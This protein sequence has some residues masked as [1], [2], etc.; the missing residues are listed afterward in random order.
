MPL[1][2]IIRKVGGIELGYVAV[3]PRNEAIYGL[4]KENESLCYMIE[5]YEILEPFI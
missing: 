1:K 2:Y 5:S 4:V 3:M